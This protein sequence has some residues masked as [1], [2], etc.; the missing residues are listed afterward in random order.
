MAEINPWARMAASYFNWRSDTELT[1]GIMAG[2]WV[3]LSEA[4]QSRR[5]LRETDP[6]GVFWLNE[7][8]Q[9]VD[10]RWQPGT[11]A[12]KSVKNVVGQHSLQ[13]LPTQAGERFDTLVRQCLKDRIIRETV[14]FWE[15]AGVM[16]ENHYR[17][18]AVRKNLVMAVMRQQV[19]P[20]T[21]SE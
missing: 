10:A 4:Y 17:V 3:L 9:Y 16:C 6:S 13:L 12:W 20:I 11:L 1:A 5:V 14:M 21:L 19:W 15:I 18:L 8:G 7:W 2:L